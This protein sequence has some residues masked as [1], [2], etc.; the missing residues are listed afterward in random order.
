ESAYGKPITLKK[1]TSV[2]EVVEQIDKYDNKEVLVEGSIRDVCQNKGCW[3]IV[4]DG[5]KS[6]RVTFE[7]YGFFVPK[8]SQSKKVALQGVF[9]RATLSEAKARH[10]NSEEKTP[11]VTPEDIKGP[12]NVITMV[13]SGVKI[14]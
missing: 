13:A 5:K 1:A 10:Y 3:L 4:S 2:T 14:Y 12:Q 7:N 9:K 8:D 6:M 11:T